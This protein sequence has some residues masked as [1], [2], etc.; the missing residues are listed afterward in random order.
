MLSDCKK[1]LALC[2]M[3]YSFRESLQQISAI[4]VTNMIFKE[5]S[6]NLSLSLKLGS[7]LVT[8]LSHL[9]N[10][11]RLSACTRLE[12]IASEAPIKMI[13]PLVLFIFP[14]I[15]ILLGAPALEN[16]IVSFQF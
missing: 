15:F 7:P 8:I 16:L 1:V 11:F 14:V 4:P 9:G 5:I 3:G 6:I 12:E 10:H 13:F 2:N